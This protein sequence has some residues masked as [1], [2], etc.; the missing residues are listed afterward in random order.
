M[1]AAAATHKHTT[2]TLTSSI[3][4]KSV[5]DDVAKSEKALSS[6]ASASYS[7]AMTFSNRSMKALRSTGSSSRVR[8]VAIHLAR[9]A[10]SSTG[11][12]LAAVPSA[13]IHRLEKS[14]PLSAAARTLCHTSIASSVVSHS[15]AS[16]MS[17]RQLS[18]RG[19]PTIDTYRFRVCI[20]PGRA[21]SRIRT[22]CPL[23][24]P[25]SGWP[26]VCQKPYSRSSSG[27][28]RTRNDE[29]RVFA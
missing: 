28:A 12:T 26:C 13:P 5:A 24:L 2:T 4:L 1:A 11:G 17:S 25:G 29:S 15:A 6:S 7:S 10:S 3:S 19:R 16:A 23:P 21:G 18:G 14:H 20:R 22:A 27:S 9:A 8:M